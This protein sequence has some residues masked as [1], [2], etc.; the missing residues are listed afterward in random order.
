MATKYLTQPVIWRSFDSDALFSEV[1][2]DREPVLDKRDG[3]IKLRVFDGVTPGGNP[4]GG[5]LLNA[6]SKPSLVSPLNTAVNIS[7]SPILTS[8]SYNAVNSGVNTHASTRWQIASDNLFTTVVYDSGEDASNLINIDLS[9][10]TLPLDYETTYFVRVRHKSVTGFESEWSTISSF[11]TAPAYAT[12]VFTN[13]L[14]STV[15]NTASPLLG[16]SISVSDDGKTILAGAWGS[17]NPASAAGS[18]SFFY[19][20][21]NGNWS[22]ATQIFASDKTGDDNFGEVVAISGNG[23]VA[24]IGAQG[25]SSNGGSA[26]IFTRSGNSWIERTKITSPNAN[27]QFPT[28]IAISTD[29]STIALGEH[30]YN[31]LQGRVAVYTRSGDVWSQQG[32]YITASDY[33]AN[34]QFGSAVALS[35]DGNLMIIGASGANGGV[36]SSGK[37]YI[38]TRTGTTWTQRN[39]LTANTP[40]AYEFM[41]HS[42]SLSKD[43]TTLAVGS[44]TSNGNVYIFNG[45]QYTWT[46]SAVIL[47]ESAYFGSTLSISGNGEVLVIGSPNDVIGGVSNSGSAYIYAKNN[48]SWIMVNKLTKTIPT[49][50]DKFGVSVDISEDGLVVFIGCRGDSEFSNAAGAVFIYE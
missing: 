44:A 15:D 2:I 46:Q 5:G 37:L 28:S 31:S 7:V 23:Q 11:T 43:G 3:N 22:G 47:S 26:Y 45:N 25:E 36:I 40:I 30:T 24:V 34:A 33:A 20:D 6:V 1:G 4:I 19:K 35:S 18:A 42:I 8:S 50:W 49:E 10:V 29:G 9:T 13:K 27:A 38:F 32:S 14:F 16:E 21:V 41:G 39:T 12:G 48:T 17:D